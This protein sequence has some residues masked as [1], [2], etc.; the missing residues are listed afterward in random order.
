MP[1]APDDRT[2]GRARLSFADE[3]EIDEFVRDARALRARRAR[4]PT[5]G[6]RSAWCAAPTASARR[7]T[8][9]CCASRSRRAILDAR[10]A[11]R[12]GR[13]GRD[14][15][16]RLR[17]RHHAPERAV[18][19][20]E[21]A[22]RGAGDAPAGRG[23]AHDA[24]GL[25][26]RGAQ[27]HGLPVRGRRRGRGV[28]RHALRG[29]ADALSACAIRSSAA[30]PRKF[31]I[32]FEGCPPRTTRSPRSTTSAGARARATTRPARLPRDGGRRHLDPVRARARVLYEFLPAGEILEVAEAVL[33]VFHGLGDYKHKQRNR[34]KFLI[35]ELGFDA[36]Q[37]EFETR[38]RGVRGDGRRRAAVRSRRSR[39]SRR[40][41]D[42]RAPP[43]RRRR[44]RRARAPRRG[45]SRGPGLR[46]GRGP[47]CRSSDDDLRALG[48]RRTCARRSRRATRSVDGHACP[49]GDLTGAQLRLLGDLAQ[50]YGDGTRAHDARP[51]PALPLGARRATCP[52]CTER[53]AAAGLGR[54]RTR[55]TLADVTSCPGA[56]TCRLA[57]TQSRGLG[58]LLGDRLRA[59]PDLVAAAPRPRHQDQRLPERLRPAP[60]RRPRLP[61]Q[62]A[63]GRRQGRC[64]STS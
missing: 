51:G 53:L 46:P 4:R 29:G 10:A 5:S 28:R 9:R 61:G 32:A 1:I 48:A 2:L 13:R 54:G 44:R 22:R 43:R 30:L 34:M 12:A 60:R 42:G 25:R 8:C 17:P 6:A 49:L 59:R 50:A 52:R 55:D 58:Q 16:A 39:P 3:A 19:L 47:R 36:W 27:H 23:R 63:P 62:R 7:A 14:V 64:P 18:P 41:P 24:R 26:Q 35:Q 11:R 21:A 40:A 33:R 37:A 57:V 38:A 31:K 56:E 20:P 45:A 15:L